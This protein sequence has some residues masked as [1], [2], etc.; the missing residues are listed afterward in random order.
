MGSCQ[1]SATDCN[2]TDALH[3][4]MFSL[5]DAQTAGVHDP[6]TSCHKQGSVPSSKS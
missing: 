1:R 3:N 4:I 5:W 6:V 2:D